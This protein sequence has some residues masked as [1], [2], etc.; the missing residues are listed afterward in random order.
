M[1]LI[2][3]DYQSFTPFVSLAGGCLIG[4][5]AVMLFLGDRRI[6]GVSGI[7][8]AILTGPAAEGRSWRVFF[9]VGML[10]APWLVTGFDANRAR[11]ELPWGGVLVAGFLAGYGARIARGCTSGHGVCGLSRL[12]SRSLVAVLIFMAAGMVT[13]S[14][15]RAMFVGE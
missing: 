9:I 7:F 3:I 5:A 11:F 14:V 6:A 8:G 2:T 4:L 12:T 10:L 15:V 1:F 13:V